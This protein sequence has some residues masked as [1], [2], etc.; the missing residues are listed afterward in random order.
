MLLLSQ[1][2]NIPNEDYEA[3]FAEQTDPV[4]HLRRIQAVYDGAFQEALR[5]WNRLPLSQW[6]TTKLLGR[7]LPEWLDLRESLINFRKALRKAKKIPKKVKNV[8]NQPSDV[9]E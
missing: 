7:D 1:W 3:I 2:A 8:E 4:E 6:E 9:S 5:V